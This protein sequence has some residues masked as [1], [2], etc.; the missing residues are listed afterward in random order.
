MVPLLEG[1]CLPPTGACRIIDHLHVQF[2]ICGVFKLL[3]GACLPPTGACRITTGGTL[4]AWT[5]GEPH[6]STRFSCSSSGALDT[7]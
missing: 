7:Y 2:V 3:A 1:A 5:I 4:V 6:S